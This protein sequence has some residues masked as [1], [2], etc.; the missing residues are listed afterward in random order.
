VTDN[1]T[2]TEMER[3]QAA[4]RI[5]LAG[6]HGEIIMTDLKHYA[7]RQ[8]HVPGD[9]YTTAFNDGLRTM[10]KNILLTIED[11]DNVPHETKVLR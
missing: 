2:P 11:E 10:A 8:S 1:K 7:D 5:A 6:H 3:V 4:W 9:P